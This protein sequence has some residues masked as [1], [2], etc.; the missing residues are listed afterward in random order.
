MI[1]TTVDLRQLI[2]A[3]SFSQT[4]DAAED[5][6]F[7]R[8]QLDTAYVAPRNDVER[9]LAGFW[10]ELLGVGQVGVQDSFFDLGG[11]SL[12][13]VRLFAKIKKTY[14]VDFPMS[15]LFDAPTI[16]GSAQLITDAIEESG[17]PAQSAATGTTGNAGTK[18]EPQSSKNQ[19]RFTHLVSM[20]QDAPDPDRTPFFLVAGMFGNVLNLRHLAQ[21]VG[22]DRP[23]YGLQAR[24][25]FGDM[26]PHETFEEM[27][28]DYLTKL[29]QVQPKGPYI[30]GG[31]SG[32]GI[33]AF[34]MARQ[35]LEAGETVKSIVMLDTP[36]AN[37]QPLTRSDK[38]LVH[39]QNLQKDGLNYILNWARD[40]RL[41]SQ[42]M[43]EKASRM[44][45]T[46][47]ASKNVGETHTF[48]SD[49]I[50][51]AFYRAAE[52][53]QTVSLPVPIALFRPRLKPTH[54]LGAVSAINKDRRRIY[55]DN[56][57]APFAS[58]VNVF[59]VPG[60]H[61]SMVLEPNVR[62]LAVQLRDVLDKAEQKV[63]AHTSTL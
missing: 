23:F 34:E 25:L 51:A 20:H 13:A 58:G 16:E 57:W 41:Y 62:V 2:E 55:F 7:A 30:L 15:V 12:I 36:L 10:E 60:D 44:A 33:T 46:G 27:A 63:P 52:A 54:Y 28:T 6:K 39:R 37:D 9:T 32:G 24:G 11:H 48:Q 40:K 43:K 22:R 1:V 53:Y 5:T 35:L 29:R 59:Q 8:P 14:D 26:P 38:Y 61:D 4:D 45:E 49:A 21:L 17:T 50:E 56:G 3:A 31:F 18:G 19:T 47:I 42:K